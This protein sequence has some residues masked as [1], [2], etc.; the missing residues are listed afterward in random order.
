MIT[1]NLQNYPQ[2]V[3]GFVYSGLF[4]TRPLT[5]LSWY[6]NCLAN[7]EALRVDADQFRPRQWVV[8]K[9][10]TDTL[11]TNNANIQPGRTLF[12]EFQIRPGSYFWGMQ[13][14]VFND[15]LAQSS[16][17]V[18][19]RETQTGVGFSDRPLAC[20]G[21]FSGSPIDPFNTL[22]VPVKLLPE[23]RLILDPGKIHVELSN[24]SDPADEESA[25]S[26]QLLLLFA[27]PK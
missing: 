9:N 25:V 3:D 2:I 8:P 19:I 10:F 6:W 1:D 7:M 18:I 13:F 14:A 23:P 24:D 16:F 5:G 17:S 20:S 15:E 4:G 12:Y 26:C 27:E 21:I 22:K 11:N